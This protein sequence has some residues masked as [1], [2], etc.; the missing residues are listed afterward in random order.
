MTTATVEVTYEYSTLDDEVVSAV[1]PDRAPLILIRDAARL[2]GVKYDDIYRARHDAEFANVWEAKQHADNIFRRVLLAWL[3]HS[4]LSITLNREMVADG[5]REHLAREERMRSAASAADLSR[6]AFPD[7]EGVP[8]PVDPGDEGWVHYVAL[9]D[10]QTNDHP[11]DLEA[12]H[13]LI[14]TLGLTRQVFDRDL[15]VFESACLCQLKIDGHAAA[16]AARVLAHDSYIQARGGP[17]E[18]TARSVLGHADRELATAR[19]APDELRRL[20]RE[21]PPLF[22]ASIDPPRLLSS[23]SDLKTKAKASKKS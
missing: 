15:A 17:S 1:G 18:H 14:A 12:L 19:T 16:E 2:L 3:E 9:L 4:G 5:R 6:Q 7:D 20:A 8:E 13:A 11:V 23:K 22:D 21:R 10:A